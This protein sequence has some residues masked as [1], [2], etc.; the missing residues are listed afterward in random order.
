MSDLAGAIRAL[1]VETGLSYERLAH[2]LGCG[3]QTMSRWKSGTSRPTDANLVKLYGFAW[4]RA[5][6]LAPAFLAA[7]TPEFRQAWMNS[8]RDLPLELVAEE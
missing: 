5:P 3:L 2:A 6:H 8:P 1:R 7:M 4:N